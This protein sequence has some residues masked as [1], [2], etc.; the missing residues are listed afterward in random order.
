MNLEQIAKKL[1]W[2]DEERRRDKAL[3]ASLQERITTLEGQLSASQQ[4]AREL[5]DEVS[6]LKG[7]TARLDK[8]DETLLQMR[9][10][11]R[12]RLEALEKQLR[13]A[14]EDAEKLRRIETRNLENDLEA[15]R[16]SIKGIP[17]L[18][19]GLEA[20]VDEDLRLQRELSETRNRL[21]DLRHSSEDFARMYRLM[22][23]G[24]RQDSRRL[25]D[26]QGEV[27][28]LRKRLEEQRSQA[29]L[30]D[31]Q[32]RKVEARLGELDAAEQRRSEAQAAFLEQQSLWQV[33]RDR[34]WKEWQE[35][36]EQI[37]RRA[38]EMQAQ[39]RIM[40]E[41][42]QT[43]KRSQQDLEALA[44]R[45]ERRINEVT[46]LQRLSEE[47][48]RQEWTTFKANDQKRWTNYTLSQDEQRDEIRRQLEQLHNRLQEVSD[49]LRLHADSLQQT[50][51]L[52]SQRLQSLLGLVHE[53][54]TAFE[55]ETTT[56]A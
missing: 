5:G 29:D 23:E 37:E 21:E 52:T 54:T 25:L 8:M 41:T 1:D 53:W 7:V 10:E 16:Q 32:I 28:A 51:A 19:K 46:E 42:H 49:E 9:T 44:E 36:F 22:D 38:E 56:T 43:V 31:N 3:I 48:F 13:K 30:V 55:R 14:M 20:R 50:A 26:L 11:N 33:E 17:E 35:R 27:N 45:V 47:R 2:L 6:R 18:Q 39:L 24:R 34:A 4:E 12:Q 15:V 40:D